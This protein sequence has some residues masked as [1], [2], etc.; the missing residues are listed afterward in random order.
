M[1]GLTKSFIVVV[2][3]VISSESLNLNFQ[4]LRMTIFDMSG[5]LKL[6]RKELR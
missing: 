2:L 4:V 3:V 1:V 6:K 5:Q